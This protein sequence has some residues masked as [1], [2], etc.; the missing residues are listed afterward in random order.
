MSDFGTFN[1]DRGLFEHPVFATE[2]FTEREAWLWMVAAAARFA[3]KRRVG[4][5]QVEL[6]RGQLA[7]SQRFLARRWQ[8]SRGSVERFILRLVTESMIVTEPVSD[9]GVNRVTICNYDKYQTVR[10]YTEPDNGPP[11]SQREQNLSTTSDSVVGGGVARARESSC[12]ISEQAFQLADEIMLTFGIDREFIPPGWYGAPMWFHTGL[13]GGW[14][15]EL[16]RIA[17]AKL[18]AKKNF[19]PP[20]SFK[21]LGRPIQ[22]EHELAAEPHLPIPPVVVSKETK[23]HV[24]KG[25]SG[26]SWQQSRDRFRDALANFGDRLDDSGPDQGCA[27]R[28]Q[29]VHIAPAAGR[30]RT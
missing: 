29:V 20:Y 19:Q 23:P 2:P 25:T 21:Y 24:A 16:V 4:I 11:P 14:K 17:A 7:F 28:A 22:R 6:K 27:D 13:A 9:H 26:Y 12:V 1:V 18:R 15:P 8:W 10:A 3:R 5:D 30:G